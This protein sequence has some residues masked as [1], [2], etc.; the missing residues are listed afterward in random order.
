MKEKEC[1]LHHFLISLQE[2]PSATKI[3]KEILVRKWEKPIRISVVEDKQYNS[4]ILN[5][6]IE[7]F[8]SWLPANISEDNKYNF[9]FLYTED[10]EAEG[11]PALDAIFKKLLGENYKIDLSGLK[12]RKNKSCYHLQIGYP[13]DEKGV[14]AHYTFIDKANKHS[15]VCFTDGLYSG[16][17]PS[18]AYETNITA[19]YEKVDDYSKTEKLVLSILYDPRIKSGMSYNDLSNIFAKVYVDKLKQIDR[20]GGF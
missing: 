4:E 17:G 3:S 19:P 13:E 16:L 14:F 15:N 6:Y 12:N 1:V 10:I 9:L 11:I 2:D 18:N 8:N 5:K 7:K 20:W